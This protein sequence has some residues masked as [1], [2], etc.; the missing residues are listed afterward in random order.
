MAATSLT[1][2]VQSFQPTSLQDA[3]SGVKCVPSTIVSVVVTVR[4]CAR[5]QTAASSPMPVWSSKPSSAGGSRRASA[6]RFASRSM[7]ASSPISRTVVM[8]DIIADAS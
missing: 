7:S 4:P 5:R 2:A 6:T 8:R 1:F 3:V